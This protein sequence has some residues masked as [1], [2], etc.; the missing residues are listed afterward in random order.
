MIQDSL[1]SADPTAPNA[2]SA[3]LEVQE[4][5]AR[6]VWWLSN[7][8]EEVQAS[9]FIS[10]DPALSLEGHRGGRTDH[11]VYR[12]SHGALLMWKKC[13]RGGYLAHLVRDRHWRPQR[14]I[15]EM[16]NC[17]NILQ[18]GIPTSQ[19]LA[20]AATPAG[21]GYRVEML[22]QLEVGVRT[23]LDLLGDQSL[24]ANQRQQI[25]KTTADTI[26]DFH[27]KGWLHGDL[28]LMNI[29]IQKNE[30]ATYRAILV[31]L[32]PGGLGP[33]ANRL[34]NLTRLVRSYRRSRRHQTPALLPGEGFRFLHRVTGG[35]RD[36]LVPLIKKIRKLL[37]PEEWKR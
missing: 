18:Q 30:A 35:N 25:L 32:D 10:G 9:G 5:G 24:S 3:S 31:D 29:L 16:E 37:S 26:H 15:Q 12:D 20:V 33:A 17:H 19:I 22:I 27:E 34:S 23:L 8:T 36:L 13:L 7:R 14:F 28:N 1:S 21:I 6:T 2:D 4:S 11:P